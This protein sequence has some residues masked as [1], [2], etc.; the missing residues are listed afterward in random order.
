MPNKKWPKQDN[1]NR[2]VDFTVAKTLHC[3]SALHKGQCKEDD[4][5]YWGDH[6]HTVYYVIRIERDE[7]HQA[8][9]LRLLSEH[10]QV[11]FPVS[12]QEALQYHRVEDC[13]SHVRKPG[14]N[15]AP[16][17]GASSQIVAGKKARQQK[18]QT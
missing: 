13:A 8:F 18:E 4:Q 6:R 15:T 3:G 12:Q 17:L 16:K 7:A 2:P 14:N 10:V 5:L 9:R 1:P 11:A